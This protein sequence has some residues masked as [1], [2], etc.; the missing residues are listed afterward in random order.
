M[1]GLEAASRTRS[2]REVM[3][4]S[5]MTF[6]IIFG[7]TPSI[8][9]WESPMPR[10]PR[11]IMPVNILSM[12]AFLMGTRRSFRR[13]LS[14]QKVKN[15]WTLSPMATAPS[16][17]IKAAITLSKLP[18]KTMMVLSWLLGSPLVTKAAD[19]FFPVPLRMDAE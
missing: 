19:C 17:M 12:K 4:L 5:F 9:I 18:E 3:P 11:G 15:M 8:F 7:A 10:V 2:S 6:L 13:V 1:A 16:A 14:P